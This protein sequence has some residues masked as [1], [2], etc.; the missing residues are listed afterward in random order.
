MG[1][2]ADWMLWKMMGLKRS[3]MVVI[4]SDRIQ[5]DL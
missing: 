4:P 2:A 1:M 3:W 5:G